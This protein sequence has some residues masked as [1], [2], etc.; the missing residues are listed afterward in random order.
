MNREELIA[1]STSWLEAVTATYL[2]LLA[3]AT[4][5]RSAVEQVHDFR[6]ALRRLRSVLPALSAG[7]GKSKRRALDAALR[8]VADATGE[9]RDEEVLD[10]T[11]TALDLPPS[12]ALEH[13]RSGRGRRLRGT[14]TRALAALRGALA[15]VLQGALRELHDASLRLPLDAATPAATRT[16]LAARMTALT[17]RSAYALEH[18]ASEDFHRARIGAKKLRYGC[19]WLASEAAPGLVAVAERC[20]KIQKSLGRLHDLDEAIVRMDR[21]RGLALRANVLGELTSRRAGVEERARDDLRKQVPKIAVQLEH[22]L[23]QLERPI[24]EVPS[25]AVAEVR[26]PQAHA[27]AGAELSSDDSGPRRADELPRREGVA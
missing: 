22:A 21:A 1:R 15:P 5:E 6:V 10:E 26:A 9:T 20:A 27:D 11:L 18:G 13:W 8:E 23:K 24:A 3:P 17:Q 7:V 2:A 4:D 19:E 12:E 25:A 16:L 14:R